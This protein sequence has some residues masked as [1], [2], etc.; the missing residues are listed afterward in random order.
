MTIKKITNH[1]KD[2]MTPSKNKQIVINA[3]K[4]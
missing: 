1:L 4:K 2:S 3:F